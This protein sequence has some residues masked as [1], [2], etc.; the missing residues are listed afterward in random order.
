MAGQNNT[1]FTG[2]NYSTSRYPPPA[3][4]DMLERSKVAAPRWKDFSVLSV[5]KIGFNNLS[6]LIGGAVTIWK[7]FDRSYRSPRPSNYH[8]LVYYYLALQVSTYRSRP[9]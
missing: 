2:G 7:A 9:G 6:G 4:P 8:V 1:A 5:T 3:S